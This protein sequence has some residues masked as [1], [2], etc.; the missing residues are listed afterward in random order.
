MLQKKKQKRDLQK[1]VDD[2][3]SY[4][5]SG[6]FQQTLFLQYDKELL[7]KVDEIIRDYRGSY[8]DAIYYKDLKATELGEAMKVFERNKTRIIEAQSL[9]NK[10][11]EKL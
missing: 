7:D 1:A 9:I 2:F 5:A 8:I 6:S 10:R 4:L 3:N 11:L